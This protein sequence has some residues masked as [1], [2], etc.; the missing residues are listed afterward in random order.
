MKSCRQFSFFLLQR[1]G[2][3]SKGS[4]SIPAKYH[5]ERRILFDVFPTGLEDIHQPVIDFA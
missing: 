3:V 4:R 1:S 5:M 2:D